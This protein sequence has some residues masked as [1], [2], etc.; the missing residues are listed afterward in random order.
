MFLCGS[1]PAYVAVYLSNIQ[2]N[3]LFMMNYPGFHFYGEVLH[4]DCV[5]VL[6]RLYEV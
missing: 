4:L 3:F 2:I 6:R 1:S 5:R